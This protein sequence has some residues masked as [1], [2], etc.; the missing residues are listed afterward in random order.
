M[1]TGILEDRRRLVIKQFLTIL[2]LFLILTSKVSAENL[3][4][5]LI[6]SDGV[7][8]RYN[9]IVGYKDGW[10][11]LK[12]K[13]VGNDYYLDIGTMSTTIEGSISTVLKVEEP[14]WE[15]P[16]MDVQYKTIMI[17]LTPY[18]S[19][20]T[21]ATWTSS[22]SGY[23]DYIEYIT[24]IKNDI[25]PIDSLNFELHT[26]QVLESLALGGEI[27]PASPES[28]F[29][30]PIPILVIPGDNNG[31]RFII[32]NKANF[33]QKIKIGITLSKRKN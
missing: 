33:E 23:N 21:A 29:K 8:S 27:V 10:H 26:S 28:V 31:W 7:G 11:L 1:A 22:T 3:K 6:P 20:T 17:T 15:K 13:K 4:D 5:Y 12:I 30:P 2:I 18:G 16:P 25:T 32:T 9:A 14:I 19:Y 24:I